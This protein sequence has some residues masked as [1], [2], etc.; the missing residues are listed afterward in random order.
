MHTMKDDD[1]SSRSK[2]LMRQR[3][4]RPADAHIYGLSR[5]TLYNLIRD[6]LVRTAV[7]RRPGTRLG[8]RLVD[9]E[10]LERLIQKGC[11]MKRADPITR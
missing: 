11:K 3:Y 4:I 5:S 10:S 9:A 2:A 8:I 7:I 6:G 1:E